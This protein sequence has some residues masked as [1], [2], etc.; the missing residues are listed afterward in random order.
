MFGT[1]EVLVG[2]GVLT[3]EVLVGIGVLTWEVLVG[4]GVLTAPGL[5]SQQCTRS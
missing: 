2:I 5:F 4:I 1:W 3:W